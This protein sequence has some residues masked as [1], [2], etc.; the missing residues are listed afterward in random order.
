[1]TRKQTTAPE[2]T[3]PVLD[4]EKVLN[5]LVEKQDPDLLRLALALGFGDVNL[6]VKEPATV[7]GRSCGLAP[8]WVLRYQ[9]QAERLLELI[10]ETE[11]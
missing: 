9:P 5:Y 1:M 10:T 4:G 11:V 6:D 7:L 2:P 8:G 3:A